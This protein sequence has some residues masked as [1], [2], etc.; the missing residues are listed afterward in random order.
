MEKPLSPQV[1]R[2]STEQHSGT[3]SMMWLAQ[4]G[5]QLEEQTVA[6]DLRVSQVQ[7]VQ[8]GPD[9][10]TRD[11]KFFT[12]LQPVSALFTCLFDPLE[13]MPTVCIPRKCTTRG[14]N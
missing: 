1:W 10:A 8:E 11:P 6:R 12:N 9:G 7:R 3:I 4:S 5:P 2:W 13:T 14:D